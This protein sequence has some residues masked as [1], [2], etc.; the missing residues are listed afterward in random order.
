MSYEEHLRNIE[1]PESITKVHQAIT[2][3]H[4]INGYEF[5]AW[6][7]NRSCVLQSLAELG[8]SIA[9]KLREDLGFSWCKEGMPE[10]IWKLLEAKNV[11]PKDWENAPDGALAGITIVL[12][13]W[14]ANQAAGKTRDNPQDGARGLFEESIRPL[15]IASMDVGIRMAESE[16]RT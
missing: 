16:T 13:G 4:P 7:T 2:K 11:A 1:L 10:H 3:Q 5:D 9:K 8:Q 6:Y 14:L 12:A 15:I